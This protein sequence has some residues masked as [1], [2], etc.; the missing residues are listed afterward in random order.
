MDFSRRNEKATGVFVSSS[1][2][3]Q[4]G[5][6]PKEIISGMKWRE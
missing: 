3:K 5:R 4:L 1:E 2:T 6:I